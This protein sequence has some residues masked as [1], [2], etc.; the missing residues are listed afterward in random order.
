M[1]SLIKR[2]A[3]KTRQNGLGWVARRI[4][5]EI[6][7]PQR[8]SGKLINPLLRMGARLRRVEESP[9]ASD[10][11]L[12]VYDLMVEP[13]TFDVLWF[14]MAAEHRR[15]ALGLAAL[16]VVFAG[17]PLGQERKEAAEYY[18]VVSRASWRDRFTNILAPL[19]WAV[20]SVR[21]VEILH[22]RRE[23]K[24]RVASW[25]S[26]HLFPEDYVVDYYPTRSC[27]WPYMVMRGPAGREVGGIFRASEAA[28]DYVDRWLA[29][30]GGTG[31]AVSITTRHYD[32]N[33]ARNSDLQAWAHFAAYLRE[34]GYMPVFIPDTESLAAGP[35]TEIAEF[36][37]FSE[38]AWQLHLRLAFYERAYLNLGINN[39]PAF[40]YLLDDR[41]KGIM[42]KIV[43]QGV[44]QNE[45]AYLIKQGFEIG[46]QIPFCSRFQ[47]RV[48]EDDS[49]EV[50]RREFE[51]MEHAIGPVVPRSG[52]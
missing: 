49:F 36:P 8:A 25:R 20:P 21:D 6:A 43:T 50:I 42:F 32:Y 26:A 4:A 28:L 14:L 38:A 10:A 18:K 46:G 40:L 13:N 31:R 7:S 47:K 45:A 35:A 34:R 24:A 2:V 5:I 39:G 11:L 9:G 27:D 22:D 52:A 48:W 33:P 15:R 1:A 30:R 19:A 3:D 16:H 29:A 37:H 23:V 44:E 17:T 12:V 41:A 51:A